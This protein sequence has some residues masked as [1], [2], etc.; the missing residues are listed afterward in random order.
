M[1]TWKLFMIIITVIFGMAY[2]QLSLAAISAEEAKQ[3][4]K[5]LTHF[6]A[7]M[8]GNMDGTI[9]AYT[10]GLTTPPANYKAGSGYRPDPFA[11]EK[12]LFSINAQNMAQYADKLTEGTKGLMK[13]YPTFRID[14]YKTHRTVA[15]PEFVLNQ[16]VKIAQKAKTTNE[17]LSLEGAH[18]G[19]PFPIPK[20]GYEAM[21]NHL[22]RYQGRSLYSKNVTNL[23]DSRGKII[24]SAEITIWREWPYYDLDMTRDETRQG[25]FWK[26][27][28]IFTAPARKA[29]EAGQATDPVDMYKNNRVAYQY[30]PG[31]RRT[32]LAPQIA[33][34]TPST[35]GGG[36]FTYDETWVFN[37]SMERYDWKLLGKKEMYVPYN[38]YRAI[39][40]VSKNEL[41]GPN[42]WNPDVVRWELHRVWVV[43][44]T[45]K[46]N[47]R[48]IY[49]TRRYYLDEDSW[50]AVAADMWDANG[51][52]FKAD[53]SFLHQLYD[54]KCPSSLSFAVY[55]LINRIYICAYPTGPSGFIR[56]NEVLSEKWWSP[57]MMA[58]MGE[59]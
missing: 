53:Y 22:V 16:T 18:A 26:I 51:I 21:W 5:T 37:G 15:Y 28:W 48:H 57:D 2:A 38:T 23:V 44:A 46:P 56:E 41:Y 8:A 17:G 35:D 20:T 39:Y 12:P 32:K 7:E 40:T 36:E 34:D 59:R 58:S 43:E 11:A 1:K 47:K 50:T 27:R 45:L 3:L 24:P 30:L 54:L 14:V 13:Q 29:G 52:L 9:P 19:Y 42:H 25:I 10:G 49:K 55:N 6:G 31:Q 33:F 4:G